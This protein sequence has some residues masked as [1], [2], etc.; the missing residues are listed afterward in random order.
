MKVLL[1]GVVL[2]GAFAVAS[3]QNADTARLPG[4]R[5]APTADSS[6]SGLIRPAAAIRKDS[7]GNGTAK[8]KAGSTEVTVQKRIYM[9]ELDRFLDMW[10]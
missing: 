5:S 2:L 4:I 7:A 8:A 9:S 6:G 3:A 1:T 10:R